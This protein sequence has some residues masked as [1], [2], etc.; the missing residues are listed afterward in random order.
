M[1]SGYDSLTW[2]NDKE[3]KEYVCS[4]N[5]T[6]NKKSFEQLSEDEKKQCFDVNQIIG[7]ERW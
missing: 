5:N 4:I 1:K 6:G 3:G 7:T 2:I